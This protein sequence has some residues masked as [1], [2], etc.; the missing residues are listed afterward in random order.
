[1]KLWAKYCNGHHV[2]Y[3]LM[4]KLDVALTLRLVLNGS[5]ETTDPELTTTIKRLEERCP[6]LFKRLLTMGDREYDEDN[7]EEEEEDK[8]DNAIVADALHARPVVA[9]SFKVDYM[10][11]DLG[12]VTNFRRIDLGHP[13]SQAL[14]TAYDTEYGIKWIYSLEG[15]TLQ[16]CKRISYD[17]T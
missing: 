17:D 2:D 14:I 7:E 1:M 13:F 8:R 15:K 3:D 9:Q 12:I 11:K 10:R 5:F 4:R 6:K 16:W